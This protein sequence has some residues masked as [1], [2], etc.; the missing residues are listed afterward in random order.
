MRFLLTLLVGAAASGSAL[1]QVPRTTQP[2]TLSVTSSAFGTNEPIPRAYTCDGAERSPPLAWTNVPP[3][4]RSIAI[5]VEDPDA[6]R[7][8]FTHWLITGLP[9]TTN[10]LAA[11]AALP[12]AAIAS[13]TDA[14][15]HG[16]T[17]PCPPSGRHRYV[18]QVFALDIP[19]PRQPMTPAQFK[20]A[21]QGHVLAQ[22]ALVGVYQR[23]G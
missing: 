16:W 12:E 18:F 1:A 11:G 13:R 8:T 6:P 5:L 15:E 19:L 9:A 2:A 14:G 21:I 4:T 10:E 22:G 3:E 17:G 23:R 7:G 20:A